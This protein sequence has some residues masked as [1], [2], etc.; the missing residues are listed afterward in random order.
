MALSFD[1]SNS[2]K[3]N[4]TQFDQDSFFT[5]AFNERA[6]HWDPL[7]NGYAF[8]YWTKI[9]TWMNNTFPQFK[10]MTQKNFLSFSGIGDWELNTEGVKEGFGTKEHHVV[11]SINGGFNGFTLKHKEFSGSPIAK[12]YNHWVSHIR[13]PRTNIATYPK[14]YNVEYSIKNHSAELLYVTVRPDADNTAANII[15]SAFYFTNVIP[16]KI[17]FGHFNF[18]AGAQNVV[19]IEMPFSGEVNIGAKVTAFAKTKIASYAHKFSHSGD[20]D[21]AA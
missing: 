4:A 15:E 3:Y 8:I 1:T 10:S 6:E 5:G 20:F 19:D 9:P 11:T 18:E 16:K 13:D 2:T 14:K 12:A 21:P 17:T 7:I